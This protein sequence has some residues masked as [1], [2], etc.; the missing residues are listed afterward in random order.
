MWNHDAVH[1]WNLSFFQFYALSLHTVRSLAACPV[2]VVCVW[3]KRQLLHGLAKLLCLT[4]HT[5]WML[6]CMFLSVAWERRTDP[7]RHVYMIDLRLYNRSCQAALPLLGNSVYL[8]WYS[9]DVEIGNELLERLI[10][11]SASRGS[12]VLNLHWFCCD[13][14]AWGGHYFAV[15]NI[16][17]TFSVKLL[18]NDAKL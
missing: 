1:T 17:S 4:Q 14:V 7:S 18:C 2:N 9:G 5:C 8:L 13:A 16:L 3:N 15:L 12:A 11:G 10:C 6:T